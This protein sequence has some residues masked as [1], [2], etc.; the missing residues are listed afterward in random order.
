MLKNLLRVDSGKEISY[1]QSYPVFFIFQY[2][3][4]C[5]FCEHINPAYYICAFWRCLV[6]DHPAIGCFSN[7]VP[8]VNGPVNA[9]EHI[10]WIDGWHWKGQMLWTPLRVSFTDNEWRVLYMVIFLIPYLL[11]R[12]WLTNVVFEWDP[13]HEEQNLITLPEYLKS[14]LSFMGFVC[15]S[16][17]SFRSLFCLI[18]AI[19]LS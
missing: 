15:C 11:P 3:Y 5:V 14:A 12:M 17:P 18:Y 1:W 10:R 7:D 13:V 4:N 2:I 19:P 9:I 16:Y 6:Y 8:C